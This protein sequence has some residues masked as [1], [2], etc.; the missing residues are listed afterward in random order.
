MYILKTR[1]TGVT[2][3][4]YSLL[5]ALIVLISVNA[6]SKIGTAIEKKTEQM[7]KDFPVSQ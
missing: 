1:K 3:L 6:I 4:E 5:I 7:N 2:L